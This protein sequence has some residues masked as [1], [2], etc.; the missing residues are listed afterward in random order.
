VVV[1]GAWLLTAF[2]QERSSLVAAR[3]KGSDALQVLSTGR[4]LTLRSFSDDNLELVERGAASEYVP[5]FDRVQSQLV[6]ANGL[7]DEMANASNTIG[8]AGVIDG[9]RGG[10]GQFLGDHQGMRADEENGRYSQAVLLVSGTEFR[11]LASLDGEYENAITAARAQIAAK[12]RDAR[13]ALTGAGIGALVLAIVAAV[14]IVVGLRRRI[15][16]FS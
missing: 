9:I 6:G 2:A 7:F 4:I 13:T 8:Y 1:I 3:E 12:T 16:E 10:Y 11:D 15:Q 14:A 5:D